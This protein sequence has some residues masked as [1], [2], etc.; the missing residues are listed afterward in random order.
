MRT[1]Y[2]NQLILQDITPMIIAYNEAPNIKRTLDKL[3]WARRIV[4]ID[5][6]STDETLE[7]AYRYGQ[8]EAICHPLGGV[9]QPVQFRVIANS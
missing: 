5:S 3:T 6:G 9:C 7:I 2:V 4:I 8:A 1:T